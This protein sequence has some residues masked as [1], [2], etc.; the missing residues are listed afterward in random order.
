MNKNIHY[1]RRDLSLTVCVALIIALSSPAAVSSSSPPN[2]RNSGINN[3]KSIGASFSPI[4]EL[5][6]SLA[7][8]VAGGTIIAVRSVSLMSRRSSSSSLSTRSFGELGEC[9]DESSQ[10]AKESEDCVVILFRSPSFPSDEATI[11]REGQKGKK[12]DRRGNNLTLSSVFGRPTQ[13]YENLTGVASSSE[14][15]GNSNHVDCDNSH[16]NDHNSDDIDTR[17]DLVF[18][19]NGPIH[20]PTPNANSNSNNLR[21]LHAPSGLLIAATGFA[22]DAQHILNVAAGRILS[23]ASIYDANLSGNGRSGKSV[24]PHKLVREDLSSILSDAA[25]SEGGRPLGLQ[26][27]VVGQSTLSFPSASSALEIYTIDP[28]GGW[29][30]WHGIGATIGRGAERVRS[31][32]LRR[33]SYDDFDGFKLFSWKMALEKA[34][35]AAVAVFDLDSDGYYDDTANRIDQTTKLRLTGGGNY[36][37][38]VIFGKECKK[39]GSGRNISKCAVVN[40]VLIEKC[41][42]RC[43]EQVVDHRQKKKTS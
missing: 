2:R 23:R 15:C 14:N 37:A 33:S 18:L 17:K 4:R 5:G 32:L 8:S 24:D 30:N 34:M 10:Q 27:L 1:L 9:D 35:S 36:S 42:K 20:F 11:S 29:K 40:P 28:S 26:L 39:Y 13:S 19:P 21:I 7:A 38:I 25:M 12:F 22:P 43:L 3:S 6:P 41:Y 16:E 31:S